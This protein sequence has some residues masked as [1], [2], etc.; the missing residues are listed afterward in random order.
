MNFHILSLSFLANH[1]PINQII[2]LVLTQSGISCG[3]YLSDFLVVSAMDP[4]SFNENGLLF[5]CPQVVNLSLQEVEQIGSFSVGIGHN[6]FD[7]LYRMVITLKTASCGYSFCD[8]S[9]VFTICSHRLNEIFVLQWCPHY[10]RLPHQNLGFLMLSLLISFP[11]HCRFTN[12][13]ITI[14]DGLDVD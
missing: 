3:N 12:C 4:H 6:F 8:L 13:T 1:S 14:G 2:D 9:P 11:A 7:E 5:G 10:L